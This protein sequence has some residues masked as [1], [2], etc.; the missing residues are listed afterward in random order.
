MRVSKGLQ[1]KNREQVVAAAAKFLRERGIEG[2]GVDALAKAAGMTHGAVYSHFASK[3][4]LAAAAVR[5]SADEIRE[6]WIADAGGEGSPGMLNRL[7]RSY[8]S[9][10]HRDQPGTGCPMAAMGPDATRHGKDV[11]RAFADATLA[12]ID[13][14]ANASAG[15]TPEARRDEAI[16]AISSMV[17]AIV[18]SRIVEEQTLSDRILAV[19]RKRLMKPA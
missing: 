16:A 1:A 5:R 6:N 14:V 10:A 4:E 2:I 13:V 19:V 9:R 7:V 11:R 17:G 18:L 3:E 12:M 15:E 8:V